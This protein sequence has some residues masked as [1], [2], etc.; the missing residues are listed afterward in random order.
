MYFF[1]SV[2][3]TLRADHFIILDVI[4][5][6][7]LYFFLLALPVIDEILLLVNTWEDKWFQ[8]KDQTLGLPHPEGEMVLKRLAKEIV[9][10]AREMSLDK[11]RDGPFALLAKEND[12]MWGG[13]MP[14][15]TTVVVARVVKDQSS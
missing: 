5:F 8:E 11:N 3:V 1:S 2:N 7:Y 10:K 15:D 14:D 9:E 4:V 12:I 13:G 6:T